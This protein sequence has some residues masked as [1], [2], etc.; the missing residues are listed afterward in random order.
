[1]T[2]TSSQQAERYIRY[3][4][5][6]GAV[7]VFLILIVGGITRLTQSG[8][9]IVDWKPI[10]GVIPP[11]NEAQWE[12]EFDRYKAFPEYQQLNQGMS[13]GEF[14]FIFFWEYLHRMLARGIGLVFLIPFIW[15]A[16]RRMF[17]ARQLK[18][19]M[20]LFA[21]GFAQGFM[22]WYM[23]QSGLV[24][25][26]YVSPFRLAMHLLLAFLIFGACIWFALEASGHHAGRS[27][28]ASEPS[29][30][31]ATLPGSSWFRVAFW[32]T[33]VLLV[34]Q[35]AWG[36][37]VAGHKAGYLYNTFPTMEGY[38]IPPQLLSESPLWTNFFVNIVSVQWTHRV[39]GTLLAIATGA[40]VWMVVG[41]RQGS[42]TDTV[43][44]K[45]TL[46][47]AGLMALQYL[48]GVLT[49]LWRVPVS[50]GV[51]HQ[52]MAMVLAGVLLSIAYRYFIE[53]KPAYRGLHTTA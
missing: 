20:L 36:A 3:W 7:M 51:L 41:S 27:M 14:K 47:F 46:W 11:L 17:T 29:E 1:M 34:L 12:A 35:I 42:S 40:Q 37:F 44:R 4:F 16:S 18:Q 32:S 38:W 43:L 50:L 9:S 30:S 15:F 22:G 31:G 25:D 49:L 23:V 33:A 28:G 52:A 8:L 45:A 48:L 5:L 13:M 26:P 2:S 10:S 39:L 53:M 24:D 21:L 19:S 6:A